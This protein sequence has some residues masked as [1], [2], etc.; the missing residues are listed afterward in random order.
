MDLPEKFKRSRPT[1]SERLCMPTE[2]MAYWAPEAW[3]GWLV[4]GVRTFNTG[5][6]EDRAIAFAPLT[7]DPDHGDATELFREL[8]SA[9]G[10][11]ALM[12]FEEGLTLALAAWSWED[13]AI[14]GAFFV[15]LA[16]LVEGPGPRSTLRSML[17]KPINF[18]A[19]SDASLLAN[20]IAFVLSKRAHASSIRELKHLL[21][22][23]LATSLSAAV[24]VAAREA[25]DDP[26]D[27][28]VWLERTSPNLFDLAP[29]HRDWRFVANKLIERAGVEKAIQAAYLNQTRNTIK[30]RN[31]LELH[32]LEIVFDK[33]V[34]DPRLRTVSDRST[35]KRHEIPASH[36]LGKT[37][38][39][40]ELID[41]GTT[42]GS[43]RASFFGKDD[44]MGWL[45]NQMT[46]R[47]VGDLIP[48]DTRFDPPGS[49][50]ASLDAEELS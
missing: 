21:E 39:V 10:S 24:L 34:R 36:F 44:V 28:V 33:T 20:A 30:L 11:S 2:S 38:H 25:I 37:I 46:S 8:T 22:P 3:T 17:Q 9:A 42:V 12:R 48:L 6:R 40:P 1:R 7:L 45:T 29:E 49:S 23:L 32:R 47:G 19:L 16:G 27:F 4:D 13:G 35:R 26:E 50:E 5:E 14:S 18:G 43:A 15:Q 41:A 31:A